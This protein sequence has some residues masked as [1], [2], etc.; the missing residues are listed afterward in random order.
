VS[1]WLDNPYKLLARMVEVK[2]DFIGAGSNRLIASELELLNEVLV[3][4]LGHAAAL[5]GVK[6]DV[7][8]VKRR[9]NKRVVVGSAMLFAVVDG[10]E[11]LFDWA[12]VKVD[13]HLVVLE[14]NERKGKARV[15]A[16]PE[17]ERH[18]KSGLRQRIARLAYLVRYSVASIANISVVFVGEVG[19]LGSLANHLVV[20]TLLLL[21]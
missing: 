18:V 17:L 15:A 1:V 19:K 10:I 4:V 6:E 3:R 7:V 20:T 9:C 14:G 8:D 11:A 12:K 2:L 13:L 16:V 21:G 5:V